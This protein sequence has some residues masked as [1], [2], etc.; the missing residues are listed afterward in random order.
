MYV[1]RVFMKVTAYKSITLT[2]TENTQNNCH[3]KGVCG[4]TGN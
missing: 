4:Q 2:Y 1:L 3:L